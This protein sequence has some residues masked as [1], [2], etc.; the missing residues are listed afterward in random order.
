MNPPSLTN[1]S[2]HASDYA[3]AF[4]IANG[5][6][7]YSEPII[8]PDPTLKMGK[9]IRFRHGDQKQ[10]FTYTLFPNPASDYIILNVKDNTTVGPIT[11]TIFDNS[12]RVCKEI[13]ISSACGYKKIDVSELHSG[14]YIFRIAVDRKATEYLKITI[15]R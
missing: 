15:R 8:L 4:L 12:G 6:L 13:T 2:S 11:L 14:F 5:A 9:K 1:G 10:Q 7:N 3:R